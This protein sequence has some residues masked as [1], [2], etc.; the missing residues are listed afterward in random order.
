M[1]NGT[2]CKR[3]WLSM[4]INR[5]GR[6]GQAML[7][8]QSEHRLTDG[9]QGRWLYQLEQAL[10]LRSEKK[11]V[12]A[13]PPREGA[14]EQA[15]TPESEAGGHHGAG[16]AT[17]GVPAAHGGRAASERPA[18]MTPAAA[19]SARSGAGDKAPTDVATPAPV[20]SASASA[21]AP[22]M[23]GMA[24]AMVSLA[25]AAP[26]TTTAMPALSLAAYGGAGGAGQRTANDSVAGAVQP[27]HEN[28]AAVTAALNRTAAP[29]ANEA[30]SP[31]DQSA[32]PEEDA[33]ASAPRDQEAVDDY[34]SRLMHVYQGADGVQ[35]WVRDASIGVAQSL[36]LARS[37]AD[38][39]GS[40]GSRLAAL[41]VNGKKILSDSDSQPINSKGAV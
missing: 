3:G 32:A 29:L 38:E 13:E 15:A 27:P 24:A 22:G 19:A 35:A 23:G 20:P 25:G 18:A 28:T 17:G 9:R 8:G 11:P 40:A 34:A 1:N 12:S 7:P 37:M 10:L 39:L 6:A 31:T 2:Y 4:E 14:S 5:D 26:Q 36:L 16:G 41:T 21:S 33:A 30:P